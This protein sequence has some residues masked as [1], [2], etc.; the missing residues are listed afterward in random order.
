MDTLMV[1]PLSEQ[2]L[3]ALETWARLSAH[4]ENSPGAHTLQLIDEVRYL[5]QQLHQ[6][7]SGRKE[8]PPRAKPTSGDLKEA[9]E[10]IQGVVCDYY[11]LT[12][13][14][15][16][17]DRKD[18]RFAWP[19]QIA[20][21][22]THKLTSASTS[23]IADRFGGR[24]YSTVVYALRKVEAVEKDERSGLE[25]RKLLSRLSKSESGALGVVA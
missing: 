1:F 2:Q 24:H 10:L 12:I 22:L 3:T 23:L 19:R 16:L 20:M 11:R 21:Y 7:R 15:M 17:G 4:R 8:K 25:I 5:R 14:Q 18:H 6:I 13:D 9:I